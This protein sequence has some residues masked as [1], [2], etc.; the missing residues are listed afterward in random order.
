MRL[1]I[2]DADRAVL[3]SA[4]GYLSR[5]RV[6]VKDSGGTFINL[7]DLFGAS[8]PLS[9][10]WTQEVDQAVA[11]CRVTLA[12]HTTDRE[13]SS[14]L[15]L[16]PFNEDSAVN[17]LSGT[18][19]PLIRL[20]AEFYVE[21]S[22]FP[23]EGEPTTWHEVFRG[24]IVEVDSAG[25]HV[26][27]I[28]HDLAGRLQRKYIE[29]EAPYGSAVGVSMEG[30]MS[31][32]LTANMGVGVVTFSFEA[33]GFDV[34]P[35]SQKRT[36]V[37][38][39]LRALAV[40]QL[41]WDLRYGFNYLTS[42]MDALILKE[43]DRA[44]ADP[45]S[46]TVEREQVHQT[47]RLFTNMMYIRNA[48][49]VTYSD[50]DDL[51]AAG[52]PKRKVY[53]L[54]DTASIAKYGRLFM[55]LAEV[56][57][58]NIDTEEEAERL[59][60]SALSDLAEP[61]AE[62]EVE[63]SC[64]PF[65][66][67]NDRITLEPDGL[68]YTTSK[69]LAVTKTHT[70]VGATGRHKTTLSMRG[71]PC[72][73]VNRWLTAE[74]RPGVAPTSPYS[75]PQAPAT[76]TVVDTTGGAEVVWEPPPSGPR[77]GDYE[78]HVKSTP[79]FT[80]DATTFK[81]AFAGTKAVLTG[82]APGVTQYV[83]IVPKGRN[84]R[85]AADLTGTASSEVS[86][87]PRYVEPRILQPRV[88][89]A[90]LPLNSD[91]EAANDPAAPPD[92]WS[93]AVG[94]WASAIATTTD[95]YSGTRAVV[96]TATTAAELAAQLFTCRPQEVLYFGMFYK[97][98][99]SSG[100][101]GEVVLRFFTAALSSAG[102]TTIT[103]TGTAG[104]WTRAAQAVTVGASARYCEVAITRSSGHAGTLTADGVEVLRAPGFTEWRLIDPFGE[105]GANSVFLNGWANHNEATHEPAQYR[106][107]DAG[108]VELRGEIV[109]SSPAP[110]ANSIIF[111]LPYAPTAIVTVRALLST[112]VMV[113]LTID[114][115]GNLKADSV[116]A[117]AR[118]SL[119]GFR[120]YGE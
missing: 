59:A 45:V 34:G 82:L 54:T 61:I 68:Y 39:A 101:V 49:E 15:S 14:R 83:Q 86:V 41:G 78:V 63:I 52:N 11:E 6:Y 74:Q 89:Y 103:L 88:T 28:G 50:K 9:V 104:A 31:Q 22:V 64:N 108:E 51:D 3:A 80:P 13:R 96:F 40:D 102:T 37:L 62:V 66:E 21:A 10:E 72:A 58:S 7:D 33:T 17:N 73:G 97:A 12:A 116:T 95:S 2:T 105:A 99:A 23:L 81:G 25:P 43:P 70:V 65:L 60:E 55:A 4:G 84:G 46:W 117:S 69:T 118:L 42:K 109:A 107:S 36:S 19:S 93:I 71:K 35:Y 77:P 75:G 112:G 106:R 120:Y 30:V 111:V 92:G 8:W 79:G 110:S 98:S 91:F 76:V 27:F 115:S 53:L 20:N 85:D 67:V 16:A 38:E 24:D 47:R 5:T 29:T 1:D 26:M 87:V 32:I 90:A 44:G 119:H 94:T 18:Y 114:T 100:T 57:S 113:T 48:V 56:A